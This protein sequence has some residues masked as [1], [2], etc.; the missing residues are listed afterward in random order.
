MARFEIGQGPKKKQMEW[1]DFEKYFKKQYL[2][3]SYYE[4]KTKEFYELQLGQM[5]MD[6]LINQ[7]LGITKVCALYL[8]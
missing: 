1:A 8:G 5:A 3:E 4:I 2:S 7:I 6:D